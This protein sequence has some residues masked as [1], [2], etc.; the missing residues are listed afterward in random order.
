MRSAGAVLVTGGAGFIGS[1]TV[2]AL[3]SSGYQVKVIDNLST[4]AEENLYGLDAE[5]M[6]ADIADEMA[7]RKAMAGVS[8]VVHLA[9]ARAVGLSIDDPI[10]SDRVNTGGTVT[11]LTAAKD[12]GVE[13]FVFGSSSSVYGGTAPLPTPESAPL[14]PRS[15]YA[16]SKVAGEHYCKVFSELFG[17]ATVV[18]RLFN[19]Y[20]PR[21]SPDSPYAAAIPLFAEAL[22]S[23]RRPTV[24]GN[25]TQTRDF[26]FVSDVADAIVKAVEVDCGKHEV[27]NI[28]AG[29]RHSILELIAVLEEVTGVD[30]DPEFTEPRSGDVKDSQ[31]D[32]SKAARVLGWTPRMDFKEGLTRTVEWI[33]QYRSQ[34]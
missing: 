14:D 23:G 21:Q 13:K 12:A 26:T 22:L 6:V 15:P 17:I 3:S 11:L 1:H 8:C 20:G 28:A 18:L 27:F 5:L 32:I 2:I 33:R 19:V 7:A 16:V 29:G 9:A 4:G 31:A 34:R 30:A 10:G 25:G 24:Y